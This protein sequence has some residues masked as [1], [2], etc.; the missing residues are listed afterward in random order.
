MA[1]VSATTVCIRCQQPTVSREQTDVYRAERTGKLRIVT[2][3]LAGCPT[4]WSRN[5][6]SVNAVYGTCHHCQPAMLCYHRPTVTEQ[7]P[8]FFKR[9]DCD[10]CTQSRQVCCPMG[11]LSD[12]SRDREGW[13]GSLFH[14]TNPPQSP[15]QLFA[16]HQTDLWILCYYFCGFISLIVFLTQLA[17]LIV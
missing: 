6:T 12:G 4:A 1:E 10:C 8:L 17:E 11:N 14:S 15:P 5:I 13:A 9:C 16:I 3:E 7:Y 2:S